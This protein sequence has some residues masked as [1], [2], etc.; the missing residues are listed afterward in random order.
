[1]HGPWI[2]ANHHS[3]ART[4]ASGTGRHKRR[5]SP[6]AAPAIFCRGIINL[7]F[8]ALCHW[9]HCCCI[10]RQQMLQRQRCKCCQLDW[11][12]P[13]VR[14]NQTAGTARADNSG[15]DRSAASYSV[16]KS[17]YPVTTR[18]AFTGTAQ[19]TSA[20]MPT[21]PRRLGPWSKMQSIVC[22]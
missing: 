3:A 7:A 4:P 5:L 10:H 12:S 9:A 19:C 17:Y 21:C 15:I 16:C 18:C 2:H 20:I 14:A 11:S 6:C 13:V 1:M 22:R 8:G